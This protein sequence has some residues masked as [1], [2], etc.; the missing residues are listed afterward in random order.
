MGDIVPESYT[1][2]VRHHTT[3]CECEHA[4]GK[5]K[6]VGQR[7]AIFFSSGLRSI[8]VIHFGRIIDIMSYKEVIY[9]S[10]V[11]LMS[12]GEE[13]FLTDE[14]IIQRAEMNK[15]E[16]HHDCII[17]FV[18]EVT[19]EA[20]NRYSVTSLEDLDILLAGG[21]LAGKEQQGECYD[22]PQPQELI[23]EMPTLALIR[24]RLATGE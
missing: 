1:Y 4:C 22:E 18:D 19:G 20:R 11:D 10:I 6:V 24:E 17:R 5:S 8:S 2:D 12:T 3:T 7:V 16:Y 14:D 21:L 23:E 9:P 13:Y 15:T